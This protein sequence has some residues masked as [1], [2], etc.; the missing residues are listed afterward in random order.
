ME[1]TGPISGIAHRNGYVATAGYDNQVILWS[2]VERRALAR[3]LHDHLANQC[4]FNAD[5][6]LLAS[7]SSD[8]SV[9]IWSVP[10]MRLVGILI[11]HT[12]DVEMVAFA[13]DG[14]RLATCS[15]DYTVRVWD[16]KGVPLAI[17]EGHGE[18]VISV[19]W[20]ADGR[21]ILSSSD[22]GTVRRWDAA[23]GKEVE[24]LG[25]GGVQ[26]DTLVIR[27]DGVIFAGDDLGRIAVIQGDRR[28]FVEAHAAGIKRV[29]MNETGDKLVTLSYDRQLIVWTVDASAALSKDA[30]VSFPAIIWPR[31]AAFVGD[32][33]LVLAAFGGTYGRLLLRDK[34][35]V[36][37]HIA[38]DPSVNAVTAID[39]KLV[40]VGDA[41]RVLSSDA[42]DKQLNSLCNFLLPFGQ[43]LLTGGQLGIVF[44]ANTEK[45][46]YQFHSPLNC[47]AVFTK[48]GEPHA[49]IGTYTGEGLVFRSSGATLELVSIIKLHDN[50]VKGLAANAETIFSVC[51]SAAVAMHAIGDFSL[52]RMIDK[53]HDRIANGCCAVKKGF[54]S[55]GR[56]KFLR[57]W[58][59][60]RD[61]AFPSPHQFSIKCI[62]SDVDGKTVITGSYGGDVALFD[63]DKKEWSKVSRPTSAGI[64]SVCF[65]KA[66]SRF[67]AVGYDGK[68]AF[69][70]A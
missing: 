25:T 6:S 2:H 20:T 37:D 35:W 1:H 16:L 52:T 4:V 5:A 14:N 45:A 29:I 15:R 50:A 23:T 36:V 40:T 68:L 58:G 67:V 53:G 61:E 26:T 65:D 21:E 66:T 17:C 34:R 31:S 64:S 70:N 46:L 41:G 30:V 11:G 38:P 44:D 13:P 32:D 27:R 19:T 63:L 28:S 60:E 22:D 48:D 43:F 62:A 8:H 55:I 57:L 9:R 10:A 24:V 51:A 12:D 3:G 18:D 59:P 39:G 47:G 42:M 33:E 54:A 49:I 56:D 7:A 69:F